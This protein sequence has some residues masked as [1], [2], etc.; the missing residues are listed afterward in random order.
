MPYKNLV[1][2]ELDALDDL[3]VMI[4]A[5]NNVYRDSSN[6]T[7]LRGTNTDWIRIK[8]YLLESSERGEPVKGKLALIVGAGGRGRVERWSIH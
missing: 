5:C 3:A 6:P 8:G 1:M 7:R 2:T 4:G